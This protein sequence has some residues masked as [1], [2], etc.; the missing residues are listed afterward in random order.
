MGKV[1]MLDGHS[2]IHRAFYGM[3]DFTNAQGV[4]T[5][6]VY[7]FL[8]ILFML[9]SENR[10][11]ALIVAFDVHAPTFRHEMYEAYKGNRKPMP[12]ELR[13]Q[14]P[15]MKEVLKAMHIQIVEKEGIEADDV[16]GSLSRTL[17]GD[18]HDVLIVSGDRDLL[19][20]A[21]EKVTICIP[22]TKKAGTVY[23]IYH[24]QEVR[25]V[26]LVSPRA[27][28]DVKALMGDA[29]D[30]IPGV[31][32]IG[33]KTAS[34]LIAQFGSIENAFEHI[35][36]VKP[37][38]AQRMLAEHYD[39]A[40]MSKE[41]A[42]IK[43]DAD[44]GEAGQIYDAARLES[45]PTDDPADVLYTEDVRALFR[46]LN[47]RKYLQH[48]DEISGG[49]SENG[50]VPGA[51]STRHIPVIS[52]HTA[53]EASRLCAAFDDNLTAGLT[54][55]RKTGDMPLSQLL[56]QQSDSVLLSCGETI[57]HLI[58]SDTLTAQDA[59]ETVAMCTDRGITVGAVNL[60]ALMKKIPLKQSECLFDLS[61]AAYLLNPLLN[62]YEL[63]DLDAY[64]TELHEGAIPAADSDDSDVQRAAGQALMTAALIP[65]LEEH[66]KDSG[67]HE[68]MHEIEMPLV[69]TL[70]RME[71]TGV[72]L[73]ADELHAYGDDLKKRIAALQESIYEQA[74]ETF[75]INSPKQLGDILFDKMGMPHGKKTK[76]GYSTSAKVL[77][78]LA[79]DY[80]FVRDILEFRQLA[81]LSSTY[82][83][84]LLRFVGEDGRIHGTFNQTVTATGRISSTEPNLQNIPIRFE[85]GRQIRKAFVPRE[86]CVF[87]DADYSQVEL[88]ILAHLSGD[89]KLIEAYRNAEDIHRTTASQVF[90]VPFDEVTDIQRRNA[91]AVN[92]GIVYGISSFGLSQ[93]L[94]IS[95]QQAQEYIEHYFET[96]PGI[97]TF[98]DDT[99]SFAKENG[100][101]TT[102]FGRRRPIPEL[103]AA[104][105]MQRQFGE[106]IAMN[107]PIQGTAADIMK[108]AMIRV[109]KAL[110]QAG[111][112]AKVVIQVHDELLVEAPVSEADEV[113]RIVREQME[114]A[115][116][117]SVDLKCDVGTG[118]NWY[119]AH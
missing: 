32:G 40:Q 61:I 79:E 50:S 56:P 87:V 15:L 48:F 10:P 102:M 35:D 112:Q 17:A 22:K 18:G 75:N 11:D 5:G 100:Y 62:S 119:E 26:Y 23:E 24:P 73:A 20:L 105:Y 116:D 9:M 52:V 84:G 93:G 7:G 106:R 55:V 109:E 6:A 72:L 110:A 103:T 49:V 19:Q 53:E 96:F 13:E 29:S 1:M 86:G 81:K 41:L 45:S 83:E 60:K 65:L 58:L 97:K 2:L 4:H 113:S 95:R 98:L 74:G 57:L 118:T 21:D 88:R 16:L 101:V 76:T 31:P 111:L 104:N 30:N 42:T 46:Q 71:K 108:I 70:D 94:S 85:L 115:A 44:L 27:F 63:D 43:T 47:F 12:P 33:E 77:E 82:A 69:F 99:V 25:D 117:L 36:E 107:S 59:A 68:L 14:V 34:K 64:L 91:K 92:F 51:D 80:P 39:L 38:R 78:K 8:S 90:H 67:M 28:I 54:L 89:P 114:G 66:L 37:P 3:P